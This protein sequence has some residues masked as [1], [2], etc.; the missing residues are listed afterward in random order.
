MRNRRFKSL[1]FAEVRLQL[2]K[3]K[4]RLRCLLA[5]SVLLVICAPAE[6]DPV[7]PKPGRYRGTA[8]IEF[9]TLDKSASVK[10]VVP[11][12][13]LVLADSTLQLIMTQVPPLPN[14]KTRQPSG[15][16]EIAG[17]P[18]QFPLRLRWGATVGDPNIAI[19]FNGISTAASFTVSYQDGVSE[20]GSSNIANFTFTIKMTRVGALP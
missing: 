3:M 15:F 11:V 5:L 12:A 10:Q 18:P 20:T 19:F 8:T 2:G 6:A 17:A 9:A 1:A 13:G 7:L 14:W 4:T 16:L